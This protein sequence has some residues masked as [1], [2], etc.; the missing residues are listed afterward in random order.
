MT[1]AIVI[2]LLSGRYVATAYNDR[3]A[4][5]WPPHP[6]R[7]FSAL[8]ATWGEGERHGDDGARERAALEWLETQAAPEILADAV[9]NA[10]VRRVVPVFVPVND[11]SQVG[12]VDRRKLDEAEAELAAATDEKDRSRLSK[13]VEKQRARFLAETQKA[14]AAPSRYPKDVDAALVVLPEHRGKQPRT[15]PCV[16]PA[17]PRFAFVWDVSRPDPEIVVGLAALLRRLVRIGHSSSLVRAELAEADAI[18][19]LRRAVTSFTPDEHRGDLVIRWVDP[20]QT[21]RLCRAYDRHRETEPRVLPARFVR[22]SDASAP[23]PNARPRSLFS[24]D[25]IVF[26]RDAGPRLPSV[27]VAGIARQFRRALMSHADEPIDPVLSGHRDDGAPSEIPHLAVVPLPWV[28]GPHPDG[29][30]LGVALVLPRDSDPTSRR[31]VLR[32][33]GRFEQSVRRDSTDDPP[34]VPLLLG[35]TGTLWLR[36]TPWG[37]EAWT[38]DPRAW[39]RPARRWATA[40][41]IALDRNPGDLHDADPQR[42]RRAFDEAAASV[43]ESVRRIGLPEPNEVDVVRSCVLPGTAKPRDYPRFPA[44]RGRTQRVLVHARLEF[45]EPVSGPVILGAGRYHGLGLCLPVDGDR[46][47]P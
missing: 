5:E 46:S 45:P 42:R 35:D 43:V 16:T 34:A 32:A 14:V 44:D 7:F 13:V 41:P 21:A 8:V 11:A 17:T 47:A 37:S 3:G 10:G 40:T 25:L 27:A 24:D 39:C 4:A 18:A 6:A 20:G 36:R 33:I 23:G 1:L 30:I 2:D 31:A 38:L 19:A 22:Y 12:E 9:A 28:T 29:S 15:F 26:A